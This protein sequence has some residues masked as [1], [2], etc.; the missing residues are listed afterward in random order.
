LPPPSRRRL[1][2]N[3]TRQLGY[4]GVVVFLSL[5]IGMM[6]YHAIAGLPWV[7]SFQTT[8]MLLGGMGPVG[9][10]TTRAGKIFSGVFALY[11]GLV[12]LAVTA[13]VL[14]PVFHHALHRFHWEKSQPE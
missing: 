13:L 3:L 1:I 10:I 14:A 2:H 4:A 6:G 11:A 7:D 9:E 8:A 5:A 12:F